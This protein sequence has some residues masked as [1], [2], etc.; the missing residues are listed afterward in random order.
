MF[1]KKISNNLGK[2]TMVNNLGLPIKKNKSGSLNYIII[3]II[4]LGLG[5]GGYFLY[6]KKFKKKKQ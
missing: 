6:E 5:A 4:I 2:Y 1:G 3:L